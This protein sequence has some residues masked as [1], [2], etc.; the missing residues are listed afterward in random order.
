MTE[1]EVT[2]QMNTPKY[3]LSDRLQQ[4]KRQQNKETKTA[5]QET[6]KSQKNNPIE[7]Q[8]SKT[9]TKVQKQ[10]EFHY[11]RTFQFDAEAEYIDTAIEIVEK[12][13]SL[14]DIIDIANEN[15]LD[16]ELL[17]LHIRNYKYKNKK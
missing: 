8:P 16:L 3:L 7:I 9:H 1:E 17:K 12:D 2:G 14:K 10:S 5:A 15:Y 6:D 13:I 11:E 4:H